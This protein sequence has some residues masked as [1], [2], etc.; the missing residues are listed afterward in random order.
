M[1]RPF[2]IFFVGEN[3]NALRTWFALLTLLLGFV[4]F[5]PRTRAQS[6]K[7]SS[8]N[9]TV[10]SDSASKEEVEQLRNEVAAQRRAIEKLE[11]LVEQLTDAKSRAP[12]AV[13]ANESAHLINAKL[14]LAPLPAVD[15]EAAEPEPL[16]VYQKPPDKSGS[17]PLTAGWNGE[18]F[19]IKSADG[20]FQIQP[21]GYVQTDYR[22]Y[23]GDGAPP[24]TFGVRRSRFGFQGNYGDHYQFGLLIDASA[25]TGSVLRDVYINA[26]YNNALQLQ[27][28]QFKEPFAQELVTGIT[29][30]D[31]LERGLQA[32]LYPSA[33]SAFRSPGVTIHGDINGGAFQYWAGAFN[34]KGYATNNTTSVPETVGRVRFYPWRNKSDSF[35]HEFAFGGAIAYSMSRGLSH[36]L[37]PSGTINNG[38]YAW[39]PQFPVNGNVW[40]YQVEF[41]FIHG[42]LA[43]RDEYVWA[44]FNRTGVGTLQLGG[45][46]FANLPNIRYQAWNSAITYLLTKE[47]RPENG[48]P[49]VRHPV[50]GPL[51]ESSGTRGW[52]AWELA[53]RYSG[54]QG[55]EPGIF[56]NN[57]FTPQLVPAFDQHTDQFVVGVNW[58]LNYWVRFQSNVDINRLKQPSTIGATPQTY[59]AFAQRL[60]FRF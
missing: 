1:V 38:A 45:L 42:P 52:G 46:G 21:Y 3:M 15:A 55:N 44:S 26:K 49:R 32:A 59:L 17:A 25:T 12:G 50:F 10:T 43:L 16:E 34:G 9:A 23:T 2:L 8:G 7:A 31:F 41:T 4:G 57:L 6:E 33:A 56:F 39:F 36:E 24:D 37:S 58:Y 27:A 22:S 29:N 5:G 28:G 19:Y 54:I 35:F 47:R 30:I 14:P 53:F 40:R 60:Q 48:T 11:M 51:T 20:Q 13:P 18:H